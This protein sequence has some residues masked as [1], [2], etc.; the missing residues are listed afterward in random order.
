[1]RAAAH[2]TLPT[3][4]LVASYQA[5]FQAASGCAALA[6][7]AP[8]GAQCLFDKVLKSM[9]NRHIKFFKYS[10]CA[11]CSRWRSLPDQGS[12]SLCG[13]ITNNQRFSV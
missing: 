11:P 12:N 1:V 4:L 7:Q 3:P 2:K 10:T 13:Q 5:A 6:S 8:Y 9:I